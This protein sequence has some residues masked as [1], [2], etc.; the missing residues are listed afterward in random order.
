MFNFEQIK[1]TLSKNGY[2]YKQFLGRDDISSVLICQSNNYNHEFAVRRIIKNKMT[3]NEINHAI[4]LAHPNIMKLYDVFEDTVAQYLVI[5]YCS[6]GTIQQKGRLSYEKF[7]FYA[8][9]ILETISFYHT[10]KIAHREIAPYNI[11]IDHNDNIKIADFKTNIH[12]STTK[13]NEILNNLMFQ[14]PEMFLSDEICPFKADIWALGITF[15]FMATGNY[16]FQ[17]NDVEE[18]KRMISKNEMNFFKY[19]IHPKIRFLISKMTVKNKFVR[20]SADELLKLPIFSNN[21]NKSLVCFR[22]PIVKKNMSVKLEIPIL[23]FDIQNENNNPKQKRVKFNPII[24]I[25]GKC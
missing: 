3:E 11:F 22:K 25:N 20:L 21:F 24:E 5:E 17:S 10:N 13:S 15:F 9:Q 2:E 19:K 1:E 4:S 12:I 6:N 23:L 7:V 8:K 18:L 16:P 14:A